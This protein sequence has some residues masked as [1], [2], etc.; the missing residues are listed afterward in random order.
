MEQEEY[1]T[2]QSS[3]GMSITV[4]K[5]VA[6]RLGLH[7]GQRLLNAEQDFAVIHADTT[8]GLKEVVEEMQAIN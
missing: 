1:V 8:E 6:A 2:I 5:V 7:D 3:G 4:R